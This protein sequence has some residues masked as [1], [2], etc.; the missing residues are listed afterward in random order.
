[1]ANAIIGALRVMLGMDTAA[2]EKGAD[3][4]EKRMAKMRKSMERMGRQMTKAGARMS[5]ALT[6]P[7]VGLAYKSVAAQKDQERAIASVSQ[8]LRSMG[9]GA[10]YTL[11][12]LEKMA[13]KLQ[14]KSLYGDEEILSKVTAN[15][16]TFGNVQGEVFGRAQQLAVDL[17]ARL[18]QDLQSSAIMLGKALNDPVKGL[19]AL[20]RVGVSFTEQQQAMIKEMA[21]AGDVAGAQ[22][23]ML[24]EL[25]RQY[26]GQAEALA[27]TD[28]GRIQQAWNAI[29]DA[30]EKIGAVILPVMAEFADHVKSLAERFQNLSPETQ[31]FIVIGGALAAAIGPVLTALGL[32]VTA[33]AP[34]AGLFAALVSPIGLVAAGVAALGTAIYS[35]WD[36]LKSEFPGIAGAIEGG[37]DRMSG[38]FGR[39]SEAGRVS[40]DGLTDYLRSAGRTV[41]ALIQGDFA[42]AWAGL[43]DMFAA[44]KDTILGV[45]DVL[46]GSVDEKLL[47]IAGNM[48]APFRSFGAD[49]QGALSMDPAVLGEVVGR[50]LGGAVL[51]VQGAGQKIGDAMRAI[52]AVIRAVFAG[53]FAAVWGEGEATIRDFGARAVAALTS[54]SDQMLTAAKQI[55]GYIVD[56]IRAGLA[57]KWESLKGYI[58][59]LADGLVRGFKDKLDIRSPSRVFRALGRFIAEGLGLGISD[60]QGLVGEAGKRLADAVLPK[61]LAAGFSKVSGAL[62]D[63]GRNGKSAFS[64]LQ[65]EL[66][67]A[68]T[69]A[70]SLTGALANMAKVLANHFGKLAASGLTNAFSGLFGG[71]EDFFGALFGGL[72]GFQNGGQFQVGGVGGIDSQ[73]VAFRASPNETVTVTKPG[74]SV[75]GG[76][77]GFVWNG[78]MVVNSQSD[79]PQEVAQET[80]AQFKAL[81]VGITNGQIA[82]ATRAGGVIDSKY[83]Q[84]SGF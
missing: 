32:M 15:L 7:L 14:E 16:L 54:I 23:L 61:N 39:I 21:K 76:G 55:G 72:L 5:A 46:M 27:K 62:K 68:I 74:Q 52:P 45:L 13:S 18:G 50:A 6:A 80:I 30:M 48:L 49:V 3:A 29:G 69:T 84:K 31:K 1:M 24:A 19:T 17:S 59:G 25:E 83:Q 77:G 22:A 34:L 20:S 81:A 66:A 79:N 33:V 60:G 73:L 44:Q 26:S 12:Q 82:E 57:E 65:S 4:S 11:G 2:F 70:D 56:G 71:G 67:G 64:G 10:G 36:S 28:S 63:V 9:D 42:S 51:A 38:A 8:A 58:G 37:I 40:L 41:E 53:D 47:A 43:G 78:N 35:N 75:G